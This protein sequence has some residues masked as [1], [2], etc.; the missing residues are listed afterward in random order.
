[1]V[2]KFEELIDLLG[3]KLCEGCNA[4]SETVCWNCTDIIIDQ[5]NKTI[6]RDNFDT[7]K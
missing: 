6:M 1:M 3:E 2:V 5:H 7:D 4:T